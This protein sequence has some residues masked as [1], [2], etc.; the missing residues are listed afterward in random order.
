MLILGSGGGSLASLLRD[1]FRLTL[2]DVS[3]PMLRVSKQLNPGC[4]HVLGD[5]R[6]I[7]LPERF[8]AVCATDGLSYMTTPA[9]L[10]AA[11]RT[12]FEH[13]LPG[14]MAIFWP[15]FVGED[16]PAE[17][18]SCRVERDDTELTYVR[19]LYPSVPGYTSWFVYL[20]RQ[21]ARTWLK[22]EH[23]Q[24]GL[25]SEAAWLEIMR[26]VGFEAQAVRWES[27]PWRQDACALLGV[28]P[29]EAE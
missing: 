28:R 10:E 22:E 5:M 20:F 1:R 18:Y 8:T 12:A 21:G 15:E 24:H 4:V 13:C 2:V 27:R 23:H 19:W 6:T 14:G 17:S 25:F 3:L 29:L 16:V 26:R 7:R 11:I 9:D